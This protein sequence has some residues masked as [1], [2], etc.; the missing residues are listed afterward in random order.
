MRP[1]AAVRGASGEI[2][3]VQAVSIEEA[4]LQANIPMIVKR[5]TNPRNHL[6]GEARIRIV[7]RIAERVQAVACLHSGHT[8]ASSDKAVQAIIVAKIEQAVEHEA[9]NARVTA[10]IVIDARRRIGH[11][12][13]GRDIRHRHGCRD[14]IDAGLLVSDFRLKAETA[15]IIADD[16]IDI[17]PG[18]VINAHGIGRTVN[19]VT[20]IFN[21]RR[22]ALDTDIPRVITRKRR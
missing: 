10:S 9:K 19:V 22:P 16:T 12:S 11:S 7:D 17:V 4:I 8:A 14:A 20:N 3:D 18:I 2:N 5:S 6:P 15:E 21:D 13:G 1:I